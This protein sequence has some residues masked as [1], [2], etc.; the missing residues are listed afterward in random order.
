MVYRR[1]GTVVSRLLLNKQD[2]IAEL[3]TTLKD[4]DGA[5]A[6]GPRATCLMSRTIDE[7]M[8]DKEKWPTSRPK[9]LKDL[10]TKIHEYS[11]SE[12]MGKLL[13]NAHGILQANF[14]SARNI[15]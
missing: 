11:Q 10:E 14:S 1:F 7:S 15:W 13:D 6:N 4:M 9:L 3:E 12:F 8:L 5:D 2:E